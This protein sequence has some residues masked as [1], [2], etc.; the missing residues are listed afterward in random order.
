MKE[1]EMVKEALREG[2]RRA[3]V[4]PDM[5]APETAERVLAALDESAGQAVAVAAGRRWE[6]VA[7][8]GSVLKRDG[9]SA[10][11][12]AEAVAPWL[13]RLGV[14]ERASDAIMD[15][16][17]DDPELLAAAGAALLV[18]VGVGLGGQI[19]EAARALADSLGCRQGDAEGMMRRVCRLAARRDP[20]LIEVARSVLAAYPQVRACA[21]ESGRFARQ[22][23]LNR[24]VVHEEEG[25]GRAQEE[26][27]RKALGGPA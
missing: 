17:P 19:D 8:A 14:L 3:G 26:L 10:R 2:V 12:W 18:A 22:A 24:L 15:A 11:E 5:M 7:S 9:S 23:E 1:W 6:D 27:W 4:P 13:L 20:A 21:L 25:W 16:V